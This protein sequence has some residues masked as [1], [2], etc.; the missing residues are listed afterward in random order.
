MRVFQRYVC[1]ICDS[2]YENV[3]HALQCEARGVEELKLKVGDMVYID[4]VNH[5]KRMCHWWQGK[6]EPKG[7]LKAQI[8]DIRG[9]FGNNLSDDSPGGSVG[10]R[11]GFDGVMIWGYGPSSYPH[12]YLFDVRTWDFDRPISS[13]DCV[14]NRSYLQ[15]ELFLEKPDGD[16]EPELVEDWT[17]RIVLGRANKPKKKGFFARLFGK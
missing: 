11:I 5:D 17:P 8:V 1:E 10:E 9:P 15:R 16:Q 14:Y 7:F 4:L 2:A 3:D 13:C 12:V 6:K